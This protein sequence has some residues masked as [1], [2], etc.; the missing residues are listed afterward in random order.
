MA[1]LA[2]CYVNNHCTDL[3]CLNEQKQTIFLEY[4]EHLG[5]V[6]LFYCYYKHIKSSGT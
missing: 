2:T 3:L 5:T 4:E 6:I 1:L